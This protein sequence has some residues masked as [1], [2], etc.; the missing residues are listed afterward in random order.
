MKIMNYEC[1]KFAVDERGVATLTLNR[2]NVHNALSAQLIADLQHVCDEIDCSSNIRVVVLTGAGAS[3][4]AGGDLAWMK[5]NM[6]QPRDQRI[7]ESGYLS[8]LLNTLNKLSKPLIG[9]VNGIAFGGG[10]GMVSVCDFAVCSDTATFGLTEVKLGL[11]PSTIS[12]FVVRRIGEAHARRNFLNARLVNAQE[13]NVMNL[14]ATV[15]PAP[16]LDE[17][18]EKEIALILKCG[19]NSISAAKK[20]IDYVATHSEEE[21][22]SYTTESL[23]DIWE[24]DEAKEGIDAFFNKTK[25]N[26][27]N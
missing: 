6:G 13:A 27:I 22:A 24:T 10:V 8:R 5:S 12:P 9:K 1:I 20:L 14:V 4:C 15:V 19:P 26:W 3:F 17:A 21:C 18:V 23:A 2:P 11:I 25:P 16:E 7:E